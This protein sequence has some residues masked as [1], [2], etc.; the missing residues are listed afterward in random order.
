MVTDAWV[1]RC[2]TI[3]MIQSL[4]LNYELHEPLAQFNEYLALHNQDTSVI[5]SLFFLF[6]PLEEVLKAGLLPI[7]QDAAAIDAGG[8][9]C[10]GQRCA[11]EQGKAQ[12]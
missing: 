11:K 6:H 7:V 9:P 8:E 3:R 4:V 1:T 5:R 12:D 2:I 10:D